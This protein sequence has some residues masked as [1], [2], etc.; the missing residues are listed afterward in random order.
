[1]MEYG[2]FTYRK[3]DE[4]SEIKKWDEKLPLPN[5][6]KLKKNAIRM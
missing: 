6:N 3:Y 1:M 4:Y 5:N 2:P